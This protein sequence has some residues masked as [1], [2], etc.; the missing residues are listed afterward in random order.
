MLLFRGFGPVLIAPFARYRLRVIVLA[1]FRSFQNVE[2]LQ[3][4]KPLIG[5]LGE[6][7]CRFF[8]LFS[9]GLFGS[10]AQNVSERDDR[11]RGDCAVLIP[12]SG[13]GG[14]VCSAGQPEAFRAGGF[15][16]YGRD[17][18]SGR[19]A[20]RVEQFNGGIVGGA[21]RRPPDQRVI[22]AFKPTGAALR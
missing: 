4:P 11:K 1:F 14:S 8:G 20:V 10:L 21:I 6:L 3:K 17:C 9:P 13:E 16:W 22:N 18:C 15:R 12:Q 5:F 19:I 7:G 2:C